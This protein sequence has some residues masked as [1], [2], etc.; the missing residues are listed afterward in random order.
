MMQAKNLCQIP[1]VKK[2]DATS[3]RRVI[4]HVS[5]HINVLQ[6]LSLN[7]TVQDLML[8]HLILTSVDDQSQLDWELV[9]APR[10]DIPTSAD[11]NTFWK[12]D[13]GLWNSFSPNN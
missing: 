12:P 7:V 6:P 3:L 11:F 2:G 8:N 5:S 4:N 13:V 1:H 10:A 9:T